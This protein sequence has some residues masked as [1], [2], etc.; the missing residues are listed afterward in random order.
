MTFRS[1][2]AISTFV[3]SAEAELLL[4]SVTVNMP[5]H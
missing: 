3:G 5:Y 4:L 2:E 1:A